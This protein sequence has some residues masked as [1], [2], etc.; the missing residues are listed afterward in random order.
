MYVYP[1][2]KWIARI[3]VDSGRYCWNILK[4]PLAASQNFEYKM[5]NILDKP[6][7]ASSHVNVLSYVWLIRNCIYTEC[8]RIHQCAAWCLQCLQVQGPPQRA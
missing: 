3:C 4:S 5:S 2:L 7:E 1:P 8:L 6:L